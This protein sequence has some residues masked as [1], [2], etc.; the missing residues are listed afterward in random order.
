MQTAIRQVTRSDT[1]APSLYRKQETRAALQALN[2]FLL[3]SPRRLF[4][5]ADF[6]PLWDEYGY[7]TTILKDAGLRLE[8]DIRIGGKTRD[9]WIRRNDEHVVG[10]SGA[11]AQYRLAGSEDWLSAADVWQW[12]RSCSG[13]R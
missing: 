11:E 3:Q 9:C 13:Q 7:C 2:M 1:S 6:S 12:G 10:I 4:E 8:R 5:W